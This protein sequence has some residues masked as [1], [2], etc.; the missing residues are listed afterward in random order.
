M[1]SVGIKRIA[2]TVMTTVT[3]INTGLMDAFD[4]DGV[5][6]TGKS[7]KISR[8]LLLVRNAIGRMI[9]GNKKAMIYYH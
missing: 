3:D 4:G 9:T 5:L 1:S 2:H 8:Q 6:G 7:K